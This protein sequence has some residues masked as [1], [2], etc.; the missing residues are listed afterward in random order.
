MVFGVTSRLPPCQGINFVTDYIRYSK[1]FA[2]NSE[3][4][5]DEEQKTHAMSSTDGSNTN[6]PAERA[7]Y[8]WSF[9]IRMNFD[10][11]TFRTYG[12]T[13]GGGKRKRAPSLQPDLEIEREAKRQKIKHNKAVA[14]TTS[15]ITIGSTSMCDMN[16]DKCLLMYTEDTEAAASSTATTSA[17]AAAAAAAA[18][19]AAI[20]AKKKTKKCEMYTQANTKL[21]S[22]A[23]K[24]AGPHNKKYHQL[25]KKS[26]RLAR[27]AR[28]A[29]G[30]RPKIAISLLK[31]AWKIAKK[32]CRERVNVTNKHYKGDM[33]D[34]HKIQYD[35]RVRCAEK[36]KAKL[37]NL[38][39]LQGKAKSRKCKQQ[40]R[41]QSEK[42]KRSF[43]RKRRPR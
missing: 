41:Y 23:K 16:D 13:N 25:E 33:N 8:Q 31:Q 14:A 42:N 30:Q 38:Q 29:K 11:L 27:R 3:Q 6:T 7:S 18:A 35:G 1:S 39:K 40:H 17:T 36:L 21:Q 37:D 28:Q 5:S 43:K 15:S 10:H 19:S 2:C 9:A 22:Q 26:A 4:A 24:K 12:E 32:V 34:G 20:W